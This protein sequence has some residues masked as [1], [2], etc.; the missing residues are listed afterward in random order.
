M[1]DAGI[2]VRDL[3]LGSM[4]EGAT[5][6]S[7][8]ASGAWCFAGREERFPGWDDP[9]SPGYFP[10]PPDPYPD[11]AS[12]VAAARAA[13]GACLKL[14]REL[15]REL[16]GGALP[17][18]ALDLAV[19]PFV[20]LLCH[21]LAER[22]Q[23]ALDLVRLYGDEALR[24]EL[25]PTEMPFSFMD[26]VDVMVHGVQDVAFNQYV[27]S[28]IV[29]ALSPPNWTLEYHP[30]GI[31][32]FKGNSSRPAPFSRRCKDRLRTLL[33]NL[34]FPYTKGFSPAQVL[35]LSLAVLLNR[36]REG[37]RTLD[38]SL[39]CDAP[40]QWRFP[41]EELIRRCVPQAL[42]QAA[43]G[44][45]DGAAG[46]N[47]DVPGP[48]R[49]MTPAYAQDDAYRARLAKLLAD[50]CRLFDIQHGANYGNLLSVGGLPLEYSRHCFFTWGWSEHA[51]VPANARPIPH[52]ALLRIADRHQERRAELILVG[53]EMSSFSYRLKS[54]PQSG[55]LPA[56]RQSKLA[57]LRLMRDALQGIPGA[58]LLYRPYFAVAGGLDD[59]PYI[60]RHIEDIGICRGDLTRRM[61]AC[62]LLALDHYGTTLHMALASNTPCLA[63]WKPE[64]WGMEAASEEAVDVLR[65]AGIVHDNAES[66]AALAID[67]WSDV[68]GWWRSPVVQDARRYWLSRYATIYDDAGRPLTAF[69]L[70]RQW[71]SALMNC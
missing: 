22:Q 50:G 1:A 18:K 43:K 5:A 17:D 30:L 63:F 15:G 14:G 21:V 55:A 33:R 60:Q 19:G 32:V 4:P 31:S 42:L 58:E 6:R 48:L 39:Y 26:S 44:P 62:R 10:L 49:G 37:D 24:V 51:R 54:R 20:L 36:R 8:V 34:P 29:E 46:H 40:V 59:G 13:N 9:A 38:F 61:L 56:Y 65:R 52:P 68:A 35:L 16:F 23:R 67:I 47:P 69:G 57:F 28:R 12:I 45:L 7:H 25:L 70:A 71:F 2:A 11:A 3:V 53:T 64:D 66:A 41:A 27:Y